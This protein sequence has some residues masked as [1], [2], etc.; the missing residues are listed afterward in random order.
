V[1]DVAAVALVDGAGELRDEPGG[2]ARVA[3]VLEAGGERAALHELH[4]EERL[5]LVLAD[6]VDRHDAGMIQPGR[7]RY[8]TLEQPCRG[9]GREGAAREHLEGDDPIGADLP[10]PVDDAH[11][12]GVDA[13]E[14]LVAAVARRREGAVLLAGRVGLGRRCAAEGHAGD[15]ARW[16]EA[17]RRVSRDLRPACRT[18]EERRGQ[19]S[20]C[21][22]FTS[23]HPSF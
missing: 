8:L 19:G 3:V 2:A 22:I 7:E 11:A 23:H 14:D 9:V 5:A 4:R 20:G 12:A 17:V 13:A 1:Q 18:D 6:I 21:V 16:T 15:Q 10:G